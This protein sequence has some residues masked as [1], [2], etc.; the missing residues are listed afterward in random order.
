[1]K[2]KLASALALAMLAASSLAIAADNKGGDGKGGMK[3]DG[4]RTGSITR[5]TSEPPVTEQ[6]IEDCKAAPADD[7]NCQK[8]LDR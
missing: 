2:T 1:M 4:D 6:M 7:L 8:I 3:N 5:S